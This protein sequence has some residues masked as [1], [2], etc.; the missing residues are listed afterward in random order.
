MGGW[1]G[2]TAYLL[3]TGLLTA[4]V[5]APGPADAQRRGGKRE[6]VLRFAQ[7]PITEVVQRIADITGQEF[8]LDPSLSGSITIQVPERVDDQEALQILNTALLMSGYVTVEMQGGIRKIVPVEGFAA[9]APLLDGSPRPDAGEM[10]TTLF[11][12]QHA[13]SLEALAAI[14]PFIETTGAAVPYAPTNSI[15]LVS[16]ERRL[17]RVLGILRDI[18]TAGERK[19]A[20]LTLR[21]RDAEEVADLI[22][23]TLQPL[24]GDPEAQQVIPT[25]HGNS[26][27]V[28]AAPDRIERIR[29][30][31][32]GIDMPQTGKGQLHIVPILHA[33][34]EQLAEAL[35]ELASSGS[36]Q[37]GPATQLDPLSLSD[38]SVVV[39]R[40]TRSLVVRAEPAV[41]ERLAEVI[42]SVDR[43]QP[44]ISV[45]A[46]L[47]EVQTAR[48]F[49]LGI[50]AVVPLSEPRSPDDLTSTILMRN[51]TKDLV[52]SAAGIP[53][54][55]VVAR[56]LGNRVAIPIFGPNGELLFTVR[57]PVVHLV[58]EE[59][60]TRLSVLQRPHLVLISGE[61]QEISVGSN[62][63][64]LVGARG[65]GASANPLTISQN[66]ERRDVGV[67]MRLSATAGQE[68][69]VRLEVQLDESR[70]ASSVAGDVRRV[71]PTI[72]QR[73]LDATVYLM[74]GE[75]AVIG[76]LSSPNTVNAQSS[77]PY[78]GALP[79]FGG[80]FRANREMEVDIHLL[81]A[82]EVRVL[83]TQE[84][85][86]LET[87]R[88]RMAFERSLAGLNGL[89]RVT[90]A[91]YALLMSTHATRERAD[92]DLRDL[93][94]GP[95]PAEVVEWSWNESKRFDVYLTGFTELADA[96]GASHRVRAAGWEPQVVVVTSLAY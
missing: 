2:L 43:L 10:V 36:Q 84:E 49:E 4:L 85:H 82:L 48:S 38:F 12:L 74:D 59:R 27:I 41:F 81:L 9:T 46:I 44:R 6:H 71:G 22:D 8:I 26:L 64:I 73:V 16:T 58:A 11:R 66:V 50:D 31:V 62:I 39:H 56:F 40:P 54:E 5:L 55:G 15:I 18:D 72:Q 93:G 60:E 70:V 21:Y 25:S 32:A 80:L 79:A 75:T 34:P 87:I 30:F 61:E 17:H 42:A 35:N 95:Y 67:R 92:A 83:R 3:L 96:T 89:R 53:Q 90:E 19:L 57:L 91:P 78:L 65:E 76:G 7:T 28:H 68:G 29:E 63:P 23:S 86:Q 45:E 14:T 24:A 1:R 88:R 94:E 52:A 13:D 77:I 37:A 47:F 20:I 51:T 69:P 33:D